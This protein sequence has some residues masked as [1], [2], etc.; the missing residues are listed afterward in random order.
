MKQN[1]KLGQTL[2]EVISS[3]VLKAAFK[4]EN[5]KIDQEYEK[6]IKKS[7]DVLCKEI[8]PHLILNCTTAQEVISK[9][10]EVC[11]EATE[12]MNKVNLSGVLEAAKLALKVAEYTTLF[13]Q[14]LGAVP[15]KEIIDQK[16]VPKLLKSISELQ[17]HIT[18]Y[19]YDGRHNLHDVQR[20][21]GELLQI[22]A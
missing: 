1:S 17:N 20:L 16:F 9:L 3:G 21:K 4:K 11:K 19:D 5:F 15:T 10:S 22:I 13:V 6:Q 12:L 14:I 7:V 2:L 18:K 8:I